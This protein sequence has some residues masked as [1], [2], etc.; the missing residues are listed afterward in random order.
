M[1]LIDNIS[2]QV[3][4]KDFFSFIGLQNQM[5]KLYYLKKFPKFLI[6]LSNFKKWDLFIK[7]IEYNEW[8][9]ENF[10]NYIKILL[11]NQNKN[12]P[13]IMH[14]ISKYDNFY[15]I[16]YLKK[17]KNLISSNS[18][19]FILS[20]ILPKSFNKCFSYKLL[21]IVS[22]IKKLKKKVT[23]LIALIF[24]YLKLKNYKFFKI[25]ISLVLSN[26]KQ[27]PKF[28]IFFII[29]FIIKNKILFKS[30]E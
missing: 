1:N 23:S 26:S 5:C 10:F 22:F 13:L 18:L 29:N 6:K 7:Y 9:P 16:K 24:T 27:F 14:L 20:V 21:F 8:I 12:L 30:F 15:Y 25:L 11:K 4:T 19:I 2:F 28:L 17:N 3:K